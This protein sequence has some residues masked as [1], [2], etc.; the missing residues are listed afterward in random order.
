M[1]RFTVCTALGTLIGGHGSGVLQRLYF[2]DQLPDDEGG[3][4]PIAEAIDAYFGGQLDA[5][6]DIDFEAT[7]TD[8]QCEVWAEVRRIPRGQVASYGQIAE[9]IGRPNAVRAVGAAN[10][11]NPVALIVPCHRVVGAGG[12]LTGYAWGIWRKRWLLTHE[13]AEQALPTQRD[14]LT[15]LEPGPDQ[16]VI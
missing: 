14:L 4:N 16:I 3:R 13:Q 1:N 6:D 10:G 5:L 7:G 11:K 12:T 15:D 9:R 2:G 8:F